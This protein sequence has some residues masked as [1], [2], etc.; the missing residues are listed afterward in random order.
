MWIVKV[1]YRRSFSYV[2]VCLAIC[3]NADNEFGVEIIAGAAVKAKIWGIF[4]SDVRVL[5][6]DSNG[7]ILFLLMYI[8]SQRLFT[9]NYCNTSN[10]FI[11]INSKRISASLQ[12]P[13]CIFAVYFLLI[14]QDLMNSLIPILI[15]LSSTY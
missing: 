15:Y 12:I 14:L 7:A 3:K 13:V 2:G 1:K 5:K 10:S 11:K 6:P 9:Y 4:N 8:C